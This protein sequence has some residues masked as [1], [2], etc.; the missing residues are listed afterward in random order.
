MNLLGN[1]LTLLG[2]LVTLIVLCIFNDKSNFLRIL[3][4]N[5]KNDLM[6]EV[7]FVKTKQVRSLQKENTDIEETDE[8]KEESDFGAYYFVLQNNDFIDNIPDP[9]SNKKEMEL[10]ELHLLLMSLL[11]IAADL[12]FLMTPATELFLLLLTVSSFVYTTRLWW[13]FCSRKPATLRTIRY[14][15]HLAMKHSVVIMACS[16]L[17]A[18]LLSIMLHDTAL[19]DWV[20]NSHTAIGCIF[21]SYVMLYSVIVPL[22]LAYFIPR[23]YAKE[24]MEKVDESIKALAEYTQTAC[25]EEVITNEKQ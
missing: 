1:G 23:K 2:V 17:A 6:N 19:Y 25:G 4:K 12:F 7:L 11:V 20:M 22:A 14:S 24:Y 9:Y 18:F 5:A 3:F 15:Y 21:T 13:R 8:E 16:V 10:I